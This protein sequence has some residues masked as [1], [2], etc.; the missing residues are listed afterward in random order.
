MSCVVPCGQLN[1]GINSEL[2]KG[3]AGAPRLK[4]SAACSPQ[5]IV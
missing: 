2:R 3:V 1:G 5:S 4:Q